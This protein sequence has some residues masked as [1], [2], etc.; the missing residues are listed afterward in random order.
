M[1]AAIPPFLMALMVGNGAQAGALS[2]F[3]PTGI[4][5]NTNMETIGLAGHE[6]ATY[7]NNLLAHAVVT[8]VAYF[9]FGG[10]KLF[11]RPR[12]RQSRWRS[13]I[14]PARAAMPRSSTSSRSTRAIG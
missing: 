14:R 5:V 10:W 4:I 3:A 7:L 1:R 6:T 9:L 8:F 12:W 13:P 2:R 11:T